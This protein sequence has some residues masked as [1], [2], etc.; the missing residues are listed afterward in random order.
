MGYMRSKR[1]WGRSLII[2]T[3]ALGCSRAA[4]LNLG[5]RAA[6]CGG[7]A[8]AACGP[9][10]P[11]SASSWRPWPGGW[12]TTPDDPDVDYLVAELERKY[13][14]NPAD[15]SDVALP[16]TC[17]GQENIVLIFHGRGGEDRETD[18]LRSAMLAS[19]AAVGISREVA[20]FNWE[21]WIDPDPARLSRAA[22]DVGAKIGRELAAE[23]PKL[24]TLHVVGTS[25][26]GF[27]ANQ[28]VSEYRA[29]VARQG[30]SR[31]AV[32]LSLTDPFTCPPESEKGGA[33]GI[34]GFASLDASTIAAARRA[35]SFGRDA[36]FAEHFV[37]MDDIV[38]YTRTP[39]PLC[40]CYDVTSAAE[41]K[42]FPLPGGGRSGDLGRDLLLRA[43]GY[44]NWPM[45][46]LA[47]HYETVLDANG[48]VAH[49]SH[50]YLPRGSVVKVG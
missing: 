4:A 32:R 29:Q 17:K 26:G 3:L 34:D 22:L 45:A 16:S 42:S 11:A 2:G 41:R 49:P 27:V 24:R 35:S 12:P 46:Y 48:R 9:V 30:G 20:C 38:P 40:Y 28:C 25:A 7:L 36:D 43:L 15:V 19:D 18:D 13:L 8:A 21:A 23:V 1:P 5:R 6:A 14:L 10:P 37:N 50:D 31:A 39:L 47:R 33:R 44:H